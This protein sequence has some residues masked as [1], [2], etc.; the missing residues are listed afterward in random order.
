MPDKKGARAAMWGGRW[1]R[2]IGI[3]LR[4]LFL[5]FCDVSVFMLNMVNRKTYWL[6]CVNTYLSEIFRG[7]GE[8]GRDSSRRG[9][10]RADHPGGN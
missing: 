8:G 2:G 3:V 5:I 1:R 7:G 10:G 9:Q 6:M 4:N